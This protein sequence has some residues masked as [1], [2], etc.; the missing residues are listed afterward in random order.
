MAWIAGDILRAAAE[1][2]GTSPAVGVELASLA[3]HAG[4]E[5]KQAS[6][7][8]AVLVD[9]GF[10]DRLQP[11]R[12]QVTP[13]GLVALAEGSPMKSG[14]KGPVP[15]GRSR[16]L[17]Q[18]AWRAMRMEKKFTLPEL[19]GLICDGDEK[20]AYSNL[21]QYASFLVRAGYLIVLPKK[22]QGGAPTSNGHNRYLLDA[23]MDTGP[24]APVYR[25]KS[26]EAYD[27]NTQKAWKLE[28]EARA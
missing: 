17:R 16:G 22:A 2:A 13:A 9:L 25:K 15:K 14:P 20:D 6:E 3:E 23:A 26:G 11:G 19:Q 10:L 7:S 5:R 18:L 12:F 21:Q 1:L 28:Q 24:L 27:P 8:C 4:L